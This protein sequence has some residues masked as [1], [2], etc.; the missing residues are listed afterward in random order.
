MKTQNISQEI[1]FVFGRLLVD[2]F[3]QPSLVLKDF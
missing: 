3:L 2:L 1:L